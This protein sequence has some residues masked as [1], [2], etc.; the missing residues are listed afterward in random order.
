MEATY[1]ETTTNK[2]ESAIFEFSNWKS[3]GLDKHHNFW[4]NELTTLHHKV[5]VGFDKLIVQPENCP[6]WLTTGQTTLIAKKK[7]SRNPSN[8][9]PTTCLPVVIKILSSIVTSWMSHHINANK[10]ILNE[11]KGNRSNTYD[12]IDQLI[13]NKMVMDNVKLKQRNIST[14]WIDFKK[15]FDSVPHDWI[16]ETLKIHRFVLNTTKSLRKTMNKWKTLLHLNHRDGQIKTDHFQSILASFKEIAC[17]GYYS[18]YRYFH[19]LGY[20][21]QATLDIEL[22]AKVILFHVSYSWTILNS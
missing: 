18:S 5:A 17:L 4:W 11:K 12:T 15:T 6:D 9:W 16:I 8:Y 7:P 20:W 22:I 2:I 1:S 13:I 19:P 10:I 3:P 21:T 14:A